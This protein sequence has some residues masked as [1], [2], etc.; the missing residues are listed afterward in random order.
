MDMLFNGLMTVFWYPFVKPGQTLVVVMIGIFVW[1]AIR[2]FMQTSNAIK[3]N[4]PLA[5][6]ARYVFASA[7]PPLRQ[8]LF[9]NDRDERPIPRYIRNWIYASSQNREATVPFGTQLDIDHPGTVLMRHS[10][11][12]KDPNY[13]LPR[14]RVGGNGCQAYEVSAFNISAMS[15]GSLGQNAITSLSMGAKLGHFYHNTGEGGVSPYHLKGGA[16]LVWQ[17]GTAKFG[18][19]NQDGS[20][21]PEAFKDVA[22]HDQVKMV[23][24]KLSQGAKPGKGGILPKEKITRE[25]AKIRKVE[26]G[27]DVI[28]PP[29][30]REWDTAE[31][32]CEFIAQVRELSGKPIGI[33]FCLGDPQF[34]DDIC[35]AFVSTGIRPD[36]VG[37]DGA[38]GGTGAAPLAHTNLLG[39]PMLDAL[40][41]TENKLIEYGLRDQIRICASGKV[42]TG[43]ALAVALAA[44][45]DWA[46]SARG[47]ML[48]VGCIQALHCNTNF[49]PAGVATQKKWLQRG[50]VPKVNGPRVA[51][52]QHAVLHEL[53]AM[54]ASCGYSGPQDLS[55]TDIMKVVG[56][57]DIRPMSEIVPYP[58]QGAAK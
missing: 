37:V 28:S 8:Y 26:M 43:G 32:M 15:F 9:E 50:L 35:K 12:P 51:N 39:Y 33:K 44:G 25:I 34:L 11:L 10:P 13:D 42:W 54:V 23:E 31:G 46:A 7:G 21:D 38:E 1:L 41:M 5:G 19:R 49:C 22:S 57:H 4:F 24:I 27:G 53:A 29:K 56:W 2:D 17:L 20:F 55:R 30:H 6:M 16:D 36:Y 58:E 52:Y 47:F 48:S 18:A 40:M 3:R 14:V 45:A